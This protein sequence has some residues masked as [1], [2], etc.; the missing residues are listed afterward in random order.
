MSRRNSELTSVLP[1]ETLSLSPVGVGDHE[2]MSGNS[3]LIVVS[4]RL[5]VSLVKEETGWKAKRSAGGLATAMDP[6]L[7]QSGG[8]WIGWSGTHDQE[9]PE[10]LK[11]LRDDQSCIAV[12]LPADLG[13]KFY[14]GYA[15]QALWPLF[16]NFTSSST[17]TQI[18]GR[19]TSPQIT[20][21]VMR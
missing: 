19:H 20:S 21:S 14:E 18:A 9:S 17:L 15:N 10:V 1:G 13:E 6:I 11:F 4:N 8:I 2:V 5:P 12:N 7:K 16:H 3:R